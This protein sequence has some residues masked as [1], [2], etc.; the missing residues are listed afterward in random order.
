MF[1]QQSLV[2]I[3]ARSGLREREGGGGR[4]REGKKR[5]IEERGEEKG[6]ELVLLSPARLSSFSAPHN[7]CMCVLSP[8]KLC[9]GEGFI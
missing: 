3:E 5:E 7:L 9:R 6:D 8:A 4:E 1:C 2:M